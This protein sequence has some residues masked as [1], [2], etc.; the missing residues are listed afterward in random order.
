[1]TWPDWL[2]PLPAWIPALPGWLLPSLAGASVLLLAVSAV[3]LPRFLAGLATD[4]FVR[5]PRR[6]PWIFR[7]L[8]RNVAG[9]VL[10]LAG[11]AMLLLP[12]QGVLTVLA[13]VLLTDLP[14]KRRAAI[15]LMRIRPAQA[16]VS[17]IRARYGQPPLLLPPPGA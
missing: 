14:G 16:G 15:R 17:A 9:V 3:F 7:R 1:M 5:P 10:I 12:G 11:I 6:R 8:G 13:G 4:F 2:P